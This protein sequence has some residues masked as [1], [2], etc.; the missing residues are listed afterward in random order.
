MGEAMK[1]QTGATERRKA[2]AE[3]GAREAAPLH[4]RIE[5]MLTEARVI[6]PGAQALLGFQ[7]V[8]VLTSTF[9]RLPVTS[10]LMHGAALLCVALAVILLVT[11]A[12]LHRIVWAGEDSES[13]LRTGGRLTLAALVPLGLGMTG[14]AYVIFARISE[15]AASGAAAAAAVLAA[16]L[17]L[18]FA[19]PMACR[20]RHTV[21]ARSIRRSSIVGSAND[22]DEHHS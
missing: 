20:K 5:Q 2:E 8:I 9:E 21:P 10:R 6:L 16:L 13:L 1:Q 4:A 11:P 14:E 17:G 7:L 22:G 19:W 18:W 3:R 15:S 12:A